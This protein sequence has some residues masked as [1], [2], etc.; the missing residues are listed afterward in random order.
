MQLLKKNNDRVHGFLIVVPWYL[1]IF[2]FWIAIRIDMK[3]ILYPNSLEIAAIMLIV[4][5]MI[6][7]VIGQALYHKRK[8]PLSDTGLL[9]DAIFAVIFGVA[10]Q[11][12]WLS[13]MKNSNWSV[14]FLGLVFLMFAI[15]IYDFIVSKLMSI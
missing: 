14:F 13:N 8:V 10:M 2:C 11:N 12:Y 6:A 3:T 15:P 5:P 7:I 4:C 9:L 1:S